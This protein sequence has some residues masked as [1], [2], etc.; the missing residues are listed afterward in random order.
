VFTITVRLDPATA[1]QLDRV[2]DLIDH[3]QQAQINK[4]VARMKATQER[5]RSAVADATN[6]TE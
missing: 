6:L 1:A 2:L 3:K 5:L 4:L